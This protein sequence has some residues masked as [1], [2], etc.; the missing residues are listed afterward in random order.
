[1]LPTLE[2][3]G[4]G[5]VPYS[6]LGKGFL[7]GKMDE[8]TTFDSSDFRSTLPRFTSDALKANQT[9][10]DMLARI[11]ERKKVTPAQIALAWLLAQKPWIVPIPG[12]TKLH[13]LDENIG[14]V[15]VE[16]TSDDLREIES[17]ASKI[18]VQGARYPE[19]LEQMTGR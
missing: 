2:E 13:R 18:I 15:A 14:A 17:A 6:P 7:T 11:A 4:I 1:V 12:T 5:F 16:L 19:K 3:L 9:L 10:I 8:K